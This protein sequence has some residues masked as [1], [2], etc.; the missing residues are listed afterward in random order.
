MLFIL[1]TVDRIRSDIGKLAVLVR[2]LMTGGCR[3][4]NPGHDITDNLYLSLAV[5]CIPDAIAQA[6]EVVDNC[7][8]II[9]GRLSGCI[10]D[11][12]IAFS[13]GF[14]LIGY[15][16]GVIDSLQVL[17]GKRCLTVFFLNAFTVEDLINESKFFTHGNNCI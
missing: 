16:D 12:Q 6:V 15:L 17:Y 14:R 11:C 9:L 3:S 13:F 4:G 2:F 10:G 5:G 8:Q 7:R 1:I